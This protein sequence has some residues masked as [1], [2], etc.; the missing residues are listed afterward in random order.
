MR[1]STTATS[2]RSFTCRD[3]GATSLSPPDLKRSRCARA[4]WPYPVQNKDD[5]FARA[6]HGAERNRPRPLERGQVVVRGRG[7]RRTLVGAA[8]DAKR[9]RKSMQFVDV[10]GQEMTPAQSLPSPQRLVDIDRQDRPPGRPACYC[11]LNATK[12]SSPSALATSRSAVLR[13]SFLSLST[14]F[15]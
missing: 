7:F 10:I 8:L 15:C 4:P 1:A 3:T 6:H 5:V 14:F 9:S 13:P 2:P 11:R 12:R